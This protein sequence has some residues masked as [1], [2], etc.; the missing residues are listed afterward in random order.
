MRKKLTTK[1]KML[2][3]I[4]GII[5][6]AASLLGSSIYSLIHNKLEMRR[7]QKRQIQLDKQYEE[8]QVRLKEL[9]QQDPAYLERLAR[10]QYNMVKPGEIEFRFEPHD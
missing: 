10:T 7:L 4:V 6:F 1:Q 8:L 9:E 3:S 5:L 2:F